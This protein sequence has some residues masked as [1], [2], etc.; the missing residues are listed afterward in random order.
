M[1][2]KLLIAFAAAFFATQASHA[3]QASLIPDQNPAYENSHAK[4]MNI[5]DSLTST[6]GTTVQNTYK[7]YDWYEAREERRKLR[8]ERNYQQ[9]LLYP[10]VNYYPGFGFNNW[11]SGWGYNR[12][13]H[14]NWRQSNLWLGW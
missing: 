3:Q 6:Q 14:H 4:Y 11:N 13:G 8:R 10:S 1:K 7:A 5:A 12:W 2:T 9:S